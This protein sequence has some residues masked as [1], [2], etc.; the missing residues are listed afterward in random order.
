MLLKSK[1]MLELGIKKQAL[2]MVQILL[3]WQLISA[4]FCKIS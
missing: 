2:A 1:I 3:F 4:P